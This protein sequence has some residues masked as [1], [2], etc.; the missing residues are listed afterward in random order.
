ME[1]SIQRNFSNK[2]ITTN[3]VMDGIWRNFVEYLCKILHMKALASLVFLQ[4]S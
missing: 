1:K 2:T 4:F 3:I